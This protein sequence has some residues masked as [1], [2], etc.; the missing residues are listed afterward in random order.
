MRSS[1]GTMHAPHLRRRARGWLVAGAWVWVLLGTSLAGAAGK[2]VVFVSR[3]A[4][5]Y[6]QAARGFQSE[7]GQAPVFFNMEGDA[8]KARQSLGALSPDA[9]RLVV[10]IGTEAA[11]S[12]GV[13]DPAIP[14]VYTLVME[15][16][17]LPERQ[18]TGVVIKLSLE[19]QF[20]RLQ[21]L[22]PGRKRV[23]V[24][25]DPRFSSRD[26]EEARKLAPTYDL[27]LMPLAVEKSE[28]VP[29]AL[30][31][32]ARGSIDLIWMLPDRTVAAPAAVQVLIAH[33]LREGVPL[34]GL[35]MYH[36]RSGALGALTVNFEDLGAQTA[37]LARRVLAGGS[38]PSFE[39]PHRVVIYIN[40]KV[41]KQ[42]G[43]EDLSVFPEV[44]FVQ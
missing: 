14:V 18:A 5:P 10:A 27:T 22:F 11:Q 9:V 6:L 36:V 33:A 1:P 8:E 23:G 35:S 25:Y 28:E 42:L 38:L 13:L 16:L 19:D 15:P 30:P 26:I 21:K 32:L 44:S 17:K 31:K 41:Q 43:L 34:I 39:T 24:I 37:R 2:V 3:S 40:P 7:F 4:D 29:E 12:L 20:Q